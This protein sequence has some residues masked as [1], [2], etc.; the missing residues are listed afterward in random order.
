MD[1]SLCGLRRRKQPEHVLR[2]QRRLPRSDSFL[3]ERSRRFLGLCRLQ[4]RIRKSFRMEAQRTSEPALVGM[5][6]GDRGSCGFQRQSG[7]KLARIHGRRGKCRS[8]ILSIR[9]SAAER[10]NQCLCTSRFLPRRLEQRN[11]P[12][13][14]RRGHQRP[15][16]HLRRFRQIYEQGSRKSARIHNG[17]HAGIPHIPSLGHRRRSGNQRKT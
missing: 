13:N 10:R 14:Q 2:L 6:P 16:F 15:L 5:V 1:S 8:R 17:I 12:G 9:S 7:A 3:P 11:H 4:G